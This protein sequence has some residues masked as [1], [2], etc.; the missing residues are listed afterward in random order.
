MM[1]RGI[2]LSIIMG[3]VGCGDSKL[4]GEDYGDILASPSGLTLT[5]AEHSTGWGKTECSACH[6]F[7]NIHLVDRSGTGINMPAIQNTVFT[8][9]N[10]SCATC[11]G[12]NGNP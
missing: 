8:G 7:N 5:E 11:H 1:H 6:N 12:N 9:G 4:T 10:G 3:L 2:F